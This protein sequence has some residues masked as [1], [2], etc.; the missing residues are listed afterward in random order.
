M[1]KNYGVIYVDNNDAEYLFKSCYNLAEVESV[2]KSKEF[3]AIEK[4]KI[5]IIKL[6]E[7]KIKEVNVEGEVKWE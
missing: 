6:E 5:I 1:E 3:N 7:N 4:K 2:L